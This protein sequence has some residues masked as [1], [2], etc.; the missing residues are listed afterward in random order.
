MDLTK[1]LS[2]S[3]KAGL[4]KVI[5]Q[6]KNSGIIVESLIDGKRFPAYAAHKISSLEDISIYTATDDVPLKDIFKK[7]LDKEGGSVTVGSSSNELREYFKEILPDFDE[8]R[9]YN[10]DIKKVFKWYNDLTDAD[11]MVF[12]DEKEEETVVEEPEEVKEESPKPKAKKKK[13]AAKKTAT[14]KPDDKAKE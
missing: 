5:G 1:I 12:E 6:T 7:I 4:F 3:G 10:S 8:E 2:I 14:K 9:V 13:A 11:M